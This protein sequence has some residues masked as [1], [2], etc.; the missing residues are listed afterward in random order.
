MKT[1]T[2]QYL[3][4]K[5]HLQL[6][7]PVVYQKLEERTLYHSSNKRYFQTKQTPKSHYEMLIIPQTLDLAK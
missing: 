7:Q 5:T 4:S 2:F 3:S 6:C 1:R